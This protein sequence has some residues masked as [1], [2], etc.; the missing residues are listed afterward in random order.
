MGHLN[1]NK[2]EYV[3]FLVFFLRQIIKG[4][5]K[6]FNIKIFT[7]IANNFLKI[8]KNKFESLKKIL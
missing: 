3:W 6:E 1:P 4:E 5:V 7:W 2:M 8:M